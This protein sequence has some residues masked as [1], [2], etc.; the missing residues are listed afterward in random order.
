MVTRKRKRIND[1]DA[2]WLNRD[3]RQLIFQ[4]LWINTARIYI[5]SLPPLPYIYRGF[6]APRGIRSLLF[7]VHFLPTSRAYFVLYKVVDN[8]ISTQLFRSIVYPGLVGIDDDD[9]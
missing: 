4:Y 3:I 2:V 6:P 8:E 1:R 9:N 7:D 5:K